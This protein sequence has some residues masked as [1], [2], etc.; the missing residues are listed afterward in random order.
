[1]KDNMFYREQSFK[2]TP[3]G[4][5]PAD[6]EV[7]RLGDKHVAVLVMGQSPPS[8]TYNR[9]GVGLPFLQGKAEF[10][11]TYPS[12]TVYCSKP[13][14]IA[15]SNDVLLSVRAPVGDVNI[16]SSKCCI[17]RGLSAIRAK[18]DKMHYLFLFH[19][20]RFSSRRF[21]ALS[22]GSTFKAIRKDEIENYKIPLP[23]LRE[24]QG[25]AGILGLVY[26]A[27]QKV[28][29][30]IA[31]TKRLKSGLVQEL[32]SKGIGYTEFQQTPIGKIPK[33]WNVVPLD[34]VTVSVKDGTHNPPKRVEEGIPLLSA[35][36]IV[37]GK[38]VR[39]PEDTYIS[40]K[41]YKTLSQR[42]QIKKGDVLL[43]IVGTIGR[44]AVVKKSPNF[45]LQR[46]V[47]IVRSNVR[48]IVPDFLHV[49]FQS[50]SFQTQLISRTKLTTQS[51]VYLKELCNIRIPLPEIRE[52]KKIAESISRFDEKLDIE[53]KSYRRLERI[54]EGLM[55]SLLMG[56][57]RI[58]VD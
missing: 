49:V 20:L 4:D 24:Q 33:P 44:S 27:L 10:G 21:E 35:R 14:K 54:K 6:W 18:S 32:L 23:P 30:I 9:E 45:T 1:M 12:P 7:V 58:K 5:I 13:R 51:G 43:T 22:M 42:H 41:D 46:S 34:N 37:D 29:R 28:D 31:K 55:D 15:K 16:A 36:N 19:Y 39:L 38:I 56:K 26:D 47:A 48:M 8:S 50:E 25:I 17:G 57:I 52:Q 11:E 2:E 40:L 3:I 53:K